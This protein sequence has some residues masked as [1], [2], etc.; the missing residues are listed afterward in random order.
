MPFVF[1]NIFLNA[2]D[3]YY[4]TSLGYGCGIYNELIFVENK[5][6]K[7]ARNSFSNALSAKI[8]R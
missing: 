3:Y 4:Y 8:S 5:A 1:K 6:L 2:K 7:R